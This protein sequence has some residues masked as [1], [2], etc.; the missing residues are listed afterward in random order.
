M[1]HLLVSAARG[2]GAIANRRFGALE[3]RRSWAPGEVP[4]S[5]RRALATEIESCGNTPLFDAPPT[6]PA[7]FA[8]SWQEYPR[9]LFHANECREKA[10]L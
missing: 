3:K 4:Y 1:E 8:H 5:Y 6:A 2:V 10:Q 7:L 9:V